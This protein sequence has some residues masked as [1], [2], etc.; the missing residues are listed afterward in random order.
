MYINNLI[1]VMARHHSGRH[2]VFLAEKACTVEKMADKA[3]D[4]S[5]DFTK[6]TVS[7]D[8]DAT[9]LIAETKGDDQL[10]REN[11]L[12]QDVPLLEQEVVWTWME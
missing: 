7:L 10:L 2:F 6:L 5:C 3:H 9:L 12:K 8:A 4:I 11:Y 1:A